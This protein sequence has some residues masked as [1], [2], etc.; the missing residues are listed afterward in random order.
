MRTSEGQT[1]TFSLNVPTVQKMFITVPHFIL[2]SAY[3]GTKGSR[4]YIFSN[5]PL[6]VGAGW[7]YH[8]FLQGD[9]QNAGPNLEEL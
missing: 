1:E 5:D 8:W 6:S 9:L 2:T 4:P 7:V 3:M